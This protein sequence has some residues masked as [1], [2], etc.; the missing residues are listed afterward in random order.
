MVK[1]NEQQKFV[2]ASRKDIPRRVR[3]G[4]RMFKYG[5]VIAAAV[6]ISQDEAIHF[7]TNSK[8]VGPYLREKLGQGYTVATRKGVLDD[9]KY[10]VWICKGKR[11]G[12]Q[13]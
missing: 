9:S 7:T 11:E 2:V 1:N 8:N 3:G 6:R 10:E 5:E 4:H 13:K 12:E